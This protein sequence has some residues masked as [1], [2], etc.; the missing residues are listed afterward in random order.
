MKIR[1]RILTAVLA[2]ATAFSCALTASA[3]TPPTLSLQGNESAPAT[4]KDNAATATLTLKSDDFSNVKGAKIKVTLGDGVTFVDGSVTI[5]DADNTWVKDSN[6]AVSS[7]KKTIT[8]VDVFNMTN[9]TT[10]NNLDLT[11]KFNVN[12]TAMGTYDVKVSGDFADL[13]EGPASATQKTAKLVI[14]REETSATNLEALNN[15]IADT[16]DYFIPYGGAYIGNTNLRKGNDGKFILGDASA[17]AQIGVLKCKLPVG[18]A[19]TTFGV[20]KGLENFPVDGKT[21]IQFGTYVN[22]VNT[23]YTYGTLFIAPGNATFEEAVSYYKENTSYTTEAAIL[24]RFITILTDP[25][26]NAAAYTMHTI[27]FNKKTQSIKA[28]YVPQSNYMW[29]SIGENGQCNKL[30]YAVRY[31]IAD[32]NDAKAM[33]YTAVGYSYDTEKAKYNFSTEIKS[34]AYKDMP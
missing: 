33:V 9:A 18:E 2:T 12:A 30:Q 3:L 29:K 14:S 17:E 27:K 31:P 10:V 20:S 25:A 23:R 24:E 15:S 22:Q 34:S 32:T 28:A 5:T 19:V 11:F 21:A 7:D 26:N 16:N 13:A 1:T 6:F 8:L 4:L